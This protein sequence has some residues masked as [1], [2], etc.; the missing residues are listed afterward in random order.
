MSNTITIKDPNGN[1][2]C[3]VENVDPVKS[4]EGAGSAMEK[5]AMGYLAFL[6]ISGLIGGA[7]KLNEVS[8]ANKIKRILKK[9][10]PS[11][12]KHLEEDVKQ[13][14]TDEVNISNI[15]AKEFETLA[16]NDKTIR[17]K[18]LKVI[19]RK[20][21]EYSKPEKVLKERIMEIINSMKDRDQKGRDRGIIWYFRQHIEFESD[22]DTINDLEYDDYREED[23]TFNTLRNKIKNFNGKNY[24]TKY[25]DNVTV[26][27]SGIKYEYEKAYFVYDVRFDINGNKLTELLKPLLDVID[28][29]K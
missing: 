9:L 28:K 24:S 27:F 29:D 25:M 14:V 4:E 5:F 22:F 20:P 15:I 1:I 26:I 8:K 19:E 17:D 6:L 23:R 11:Y 2:V 16:K 13:M 7:V 21:F 12:I 10:D 3:S 18:N